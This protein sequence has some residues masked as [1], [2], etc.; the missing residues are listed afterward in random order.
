M[1][2][3]NLIV[4]LIFAL[5]IIWGSN[6][7]F[8]ENVVIEADKQN[9]STKDN[10]T[11]FD[12]NVKVTSK[13]VTVRGP[14]AVMKINSNNKPDYALF[15]NNPVATKVS[16]TSKSQ[17]KAN[18]M[19]LSLIDNIVKAEGNVISE[20]IDSSSSVMTMKSDMQEYDISN[21]I[22]IAKGNVEINNKDLKTKSREAR[23][24][25]D[26]TGKPQE[27]KL[28]GGARVI[29]DKNVADADIFIYNPITDEAIAQGHTRSQTILDD[30]TQ[31]FVWSD[32]QEYNKNTG[33]LMT[34]GNVK[35]AYKEYLAFGP[36]ATMIK[37]NSTT[38]P[39]KIVFLGR[40]RIIENT[41]EVEA[42][43]IVITLNPKD[44][45]A[46]GNVKTKFTQIQS[47]KKKTN[48]K[49]VNKKT[50]QQDVN[51]KKALE[52]QE[53]RKKYPV[54]EKP[55]EYDAQSIFN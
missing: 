47:N 9:Y 7:C 16:P 21:N 10:M 32:I 1:N 27:V 8:A 34:S 19:R 25:V 17:I 28:I 43:R 53:F 24:L 20:V 46:E 39:N 48:N 51:K 3:Q 30:L 26:K 44:F 45:T 18:I 37:E 33:T 6:F 54:I 49:K 13:D 31:V 12:G 22:I 55:E 35:I 41:R 38:K 36:K 2:K 5:Y 42:N 52:E 14:K 40:S 11:H 29:Q 23:I 50:N 15:L 4:G